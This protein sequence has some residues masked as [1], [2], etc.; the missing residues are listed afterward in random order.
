MGLLQSSRIFL[1]LNL[2]IFAD[3]APTVAVRVF[4]VQLCELGS[5][6]IGQRVTIL[7]TRDGGKIRGQGGIRGR[8]EIV[9]LGFFG[10]LY[11][12]IIIL[13]NVN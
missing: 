5:G 12:Y 11:Y 2:L 9:D 8:Q 6:K 7:G 4:R 3:P 1:S 10:I 13:M